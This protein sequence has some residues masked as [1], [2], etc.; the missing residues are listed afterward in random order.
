[1][2]KDK[3]RYSCLSLFGGLAI[4]LLA[5]PFC[6]FLAVYV[7]ARR[8]GKLPQRLQGWLDRYVYPTYLSK[9]HIARVPNLLRELGPQARVL[10]IGGGLK[11]YPNVV[12]I[13]IQPGAATSVAAD[14]HLLPFADESFDAVLAIA[15]FEHVAQ[16]WYVTEEVERVLRSGG[17]FYMEV[18]FLQPFHADP[19][20]YYRYTPSGLR[21]IFRSF[22]EREIGVSNGPG[23]M[24]TWILMEVFSLFGDLP[25]SY[26]ETFMRNVPRAF[27]RFREAGRLL[28][29]PFK[30]LDKLL[31]PKKRSFVVAS[32][33]YFLGTKPQEDAGE[34]IT[35][36][37]MAS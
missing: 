36:P 4:V 37:P 16:P 1:M 6:F 35:L 25:G 7:L 34:W 17:T 28:F 9:E 3:R 13:D 8:S 23:S 22:E 32:G 21:S 5:I 10:N 27:L 33:V 2:A 11:E 14:A 31:E 18:P 15:V 19:D 24:L 29:A 30:Y 20:D 12:N 26:D